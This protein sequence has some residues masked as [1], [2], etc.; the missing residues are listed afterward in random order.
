MKILYS[1]PNVIYWLDTQLH[2]PVLEQETASADTVGASQPATKSPPNARAKSKTYFFITLFLNSYQFYR[3]YHIHEQSINQKT[4]LKILIL[5]NFFYFCGTLISQTLIEKQLIKI[6]IFNSWKNRKA[7]SEKSKS[8]PKQ[9]QQEES[10][11][12]FYGREFCTARGCKGITCEI[13]RT[14]YPKRKKPVI[15]KK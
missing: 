8:L 13:C 7:N 10:A 6:M 11:G 12:I 4:Y 2:P 5:I 14:C 3:R 9:P 1:E 15:T